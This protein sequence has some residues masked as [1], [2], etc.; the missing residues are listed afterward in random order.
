MRLSQFIEPLVLSL[1]A[2]MDSRLVRTLE[3]T[4]VAIIRHRH[5]QNGLL[6]S[7]LGEYLAG[8]DHAT[9]GRTERDGLFRQMCATF[10][11]A[12]HVFDR[13]Y[14]PARRGSGRSWAKT[15][16]LWCAGTV[17]IFFRMKKGGAKRPGTSQRGKK[18]WAASSSGMP[19]A[20]NNGS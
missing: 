20:R 13:G 10:S 9:H 11:E 1:D 15:P 16:T 5:R 6:L 7:E 18:P 4:V 3:A 2:L 19:S 17:L 12:V 14:M 8:P